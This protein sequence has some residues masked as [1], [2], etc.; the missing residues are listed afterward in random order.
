MTRK[1]EVCTELGETG[2]TEGRRH[3]LVIEQRLL[4]LCGPHA[5]LVKA[6]G[7]NSLAAVRALFREVTGRRSALP[8]RAELD[9]R[10][11]PPRPEGRRLAR[12]RRESE[13][14]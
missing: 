4:T 13:I 12:G 14:G 6:M 9:R 1:C 7:A 2:E 3:H 5:R 8:R 11:F 10:A